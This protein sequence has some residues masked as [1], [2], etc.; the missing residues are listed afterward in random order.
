MHEDEPDIDLDLVHHLI[1]GQFPRWSRLPISPVVSTGTDNAI[2]R[3]GGDMA[4]RLPRRPEAAEMIEKEARWLPQFEHKLPL[5]IPVPIA[6]GVPGP[7]YPWPWAICRWIDGRDAL[8]ESVDLD[9][10]AATVADFVLVLQR[11]GTDGGPRPGRHNFSR[12]VPLAERDER[13]REAIGALPPAF[14]K[15]RLLSVWGRALQ[16]PA[17]GG[18][19]VWIHGDLAPGNLVARDGRVAGVIDWGGMA[20]ADP[21]CDMMIAWTLLSGESRESFKR[22][23][24]VNDATWD[25]ARG[26][27]LSVAAI[28]I[29]YYLESS[30]EIVT[31]ATRAIDEVLGDS[32]T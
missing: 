17:L 18:D 19:P 8:V 6:T 31:W 28:A 1:R 32:K 7:N 11:V 25:R 24:N 26:W 5:E 21:A 4:I 15:P 12:G 10:A 3:L 23:L 29:P 13:T 22:A 14:D 9:H 27:T 30:P 2:Y 20:V 16:A